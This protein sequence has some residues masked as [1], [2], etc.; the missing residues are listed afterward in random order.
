[1]I[2]KILGDYFS[3][4]IEEQKDT[5]KDVCLFQKHIKQLL[6]LFKK[7]Y[8]QNRTKIIFIPTLVFFKTRIFDKINILKI[9][10]EKQSLEQMIL[11]KYRFIMIKSDFLTLHNVKK[12][13]YH[14][15]MRNFFIDLFKLIELIAEF[16][17]LYWTIYNSFIISL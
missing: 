8:C 4:P 2:L 7:K 13:I 15:Q 11:I 12:A 5:L 3:A 1:M 17:N 9:Y 6:S 14:H 16:F 10:L